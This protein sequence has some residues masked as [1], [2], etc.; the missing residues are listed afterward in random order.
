[1]FFTECSRLRV[2]RHDE[3]YLV[4]ADL[5]DCFKLVH[6]SWSLVFIL[7][8]AGGGATRVVAPPRR[9]ACLGRLPRMEGPV[10]AV[11]DPE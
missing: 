11:A 1:M 5:R 7:A 8:R 9:P 10:H 6:R 3:Y 2:M 4:L